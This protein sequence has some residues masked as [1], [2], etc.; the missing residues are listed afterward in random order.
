MTIP[1][2]QITLRG[3]GMTTEDIKAYPE[4]AAVA[5]LASQNCTYGPDHRVHRYFAQDG[6]ERCVRCGL[7]A[8]RREMRE[9]PE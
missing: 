1:T 4:A 3:H 9:A 8:W 6:T 5:T 7:D 2:D